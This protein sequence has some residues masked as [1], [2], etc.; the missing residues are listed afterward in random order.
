MLVFNG[1][2]TKK[3]WKKEFVCSHWVTKKKWVRCKIQIYKLFWKVVRCSWGGLEKFKVILLPAKKWHIKNTP[4]FK[5][6]L[7]L[8]LNLFFCVLFE[9][10][11]S[12][13]EIW[14]S[15][16]ENGFL[17][18]KIDFVIVF[19]KQTS[20]LCVWKCICCPTLIFPDGSMLKK[21][22]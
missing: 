10:R 7:T 6:S 11:I 13:F 3:L 8:Q 18:Y 21:N 4:L 2:Y 16:F 12:D 15:E 19:E 20:D 14:I 1:G 22:C 9:K 17:N 5:N